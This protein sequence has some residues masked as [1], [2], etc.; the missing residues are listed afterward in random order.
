MLLP[1]PE[2][3]AVMYVKRVF[4]GTFNNGPANVIFERDT[5]SWRTESNSDISV[6][7]STITD[8]EF[9]RDAGTIHIWATPPFAKEP[10]FVREGAPLRS[11]DGSIREQRFLPFLDKDEPRSAICFDLPKDASVAY[12]ETVN[13][14]L[15]SVLAHP[16]MRQLRGRNV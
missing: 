9:D 6:S 13:I 10:P 8:F 7:M 12:K 3:W 14:W 2:A 11:N 5:I 4:L 15:S 1:P 16:M